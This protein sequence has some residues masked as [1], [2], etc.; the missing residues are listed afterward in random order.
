MARAEG[1]ARTH[2]TEKKGNE[3]RSKL[4]GENNQFLGLISLLELFFPRIH[5]AA[6]DHLSFLRHSSLFSLSPS[7]HRLPVQALLSICPQK[8]ETP[9]LIQEDFA[10]LIPESVVIWFLIF[11][12][13]STEYKIKK[14]NTVC[15]LFGLFTF[16]GLTYCLMSIIVYLY[17]IVAHHHR[18][19]IP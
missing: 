8:R 19:P 4:R 9:C 7:P 15:T 17:C 2:W 18:W 1:K 16:W 11:Y 13:L 10:I 14:L 6:T 12:Y 5:A 3:G